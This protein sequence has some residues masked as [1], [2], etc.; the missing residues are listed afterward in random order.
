MFLLFLGGI[1]L[2]RV[3]L[4]FLF[5]T[6]LH[7]AP[8]GGGESSRGDCSNNTVDLRDRLP[9]TRS[10]SVSL[11]CQTFTS[12]TLLEEQIHRHT[13]EVQS[14]SVIDLNS[15][16]S[17]NQVSA[18]TP[19]RRRLR[20]ERDYAYNILLGAQVEQQVY[21][22]RFMPFSVSEPGGGTTRRVLSQFYNNDQQLVFENDQAVCSNSKGGIIID[23]VLVDFLSNF[24]DVSQRQTDKE[25]TSIRLYNL[26]NPDVVF[27]HFEEER[28]ALWRNPTED[29]ITIPPFNVNMAFESTASGTLTRINQALQDSRPVE[30]S[31]CYGPLNSQI[32]PIHATANCNPHS[33]IVAGSRLNNGQCQLLLR[34]SMGVDWPGDGHDPGDGYLWMSTSEFRNYINFSPRQNP[35]DGSYADLT[36]LNYLSDRNAEDPVQNTITYNGATVYQG[37]I[38]VDPLFTG[39]LLLEDQSQ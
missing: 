26:E 8:S 18:D 39:Q 29:R 15:M 24:E 6:T 17:S 34:N 35:V 4:L 25:G 5:M 23:P 22:E 30:V 16:K 37:S 33:M 32:Q 2:L 9:P 14:L 19:I 3:L 7:A 21:P 31:V 11:M 28:Q 27:Q 38:R 20:D 1:S 36:T 10:Q 13:G 12:G